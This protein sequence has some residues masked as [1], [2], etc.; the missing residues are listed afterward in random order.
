MDPDVQ[1]CV[2]D[3]RPTF[4]HMDMM[5]PTRTE[6]LNVKKILNNTGLSTVIVQTGMG[7]SGL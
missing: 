3:Y 2:L 5:K 7:H 6:M 4:R 1:V